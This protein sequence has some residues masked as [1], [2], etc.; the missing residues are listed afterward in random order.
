MTAILYFNDLCPDTAPFVA[1]LQ[2]LGIAY[3]AVNIRD[4]M[5]ALKAFLRLRDSESAFDEK[6]AK[7]YV[8]IPV[9]VTELGL[10]FEVSDLARLV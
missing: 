2:R 10:I 8:G 4:S 6:K 9:L 7:G 3:E 5:A 1:E